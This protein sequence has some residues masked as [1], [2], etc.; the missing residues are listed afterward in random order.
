MAHELAERNGRCTGA[1][2]ALE[3]DERGFDFRRRPERLRRKGAQH[4]DIGKRLHDDAE[5]AVSFG[6]RR[7]AQTV[8]NFL[9][10]GERQQLNAIYQQLDDERRCDVVGKIRD[11]LEL[12]GAIKTSYDRLSLDP[13]F[14]P[15]RA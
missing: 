4:F 8:C 12:I 2:I 9:L 1:I 14:S 3:T 10:N 11:E 6:R 7:G 13:R 15:D 5:R